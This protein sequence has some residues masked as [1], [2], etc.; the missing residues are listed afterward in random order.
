[1]A[2]SGD[3]RPGLV[4]PGAQGLA[5]NELHR[6]GRRLARPG[7]DS[8]DRHDPGV[9]QLGGELRFCHETAHHLGLV[10]EAGVEALHDDGA[11]EALILRE[12]HL[13]HRAPAELTEE[14]Q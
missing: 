9:V 1:M 3:G 14:A 4:E 8:V 13:A 5:A 10:R 2:G 7:I 6:V 11:V 12:Q